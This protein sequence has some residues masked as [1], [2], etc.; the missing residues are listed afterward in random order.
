MGRDNMSNLRME[1]IDY[2]E[3]SDM[4]DKMK[5]FFTGAVIY[6][7]EHPDKP[8]FRNEYNDLIEKLV[9]EE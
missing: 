7:W 9:G 5:R 8:H 2:I 4:D 3:E 1:I 6:E